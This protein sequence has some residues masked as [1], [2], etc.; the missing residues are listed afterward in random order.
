MALAILS[1]PLSERLKED[2][3]AIQGFRNRRHPDVAGLL[4]AKEVLL[5]TFPQLR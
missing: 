5:E 4:K 3:Q 2:W 1:L